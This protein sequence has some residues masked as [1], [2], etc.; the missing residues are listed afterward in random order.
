M[1][2]GIF[3]ALF[4]GLAGDPDAIRTKC[5]EFDFIP[6]IAQ[7]LAEEVIPANLLATGSSGFDSAPETRADEIYAQIVAGERGNFH[8]VAAATQEIAH[9]LTAIADLLDDFYDKIKAADEALG[10][11]IWGVAVILLTAAVAAYSPEPYSKAAA[12]I[13]LALEVYGIFEVAWNF[14]ED[15]IAGLID[16]LSMTIP[17]APTVGPIS[18]VG[19]PRS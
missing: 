8:L 2:G 12:L 18:W 3:G 16:A 19:V 6:A 15:V 5:T 14:F 13:G 17:A 1:S 9:S 4:A 11:A 10:E 7:S